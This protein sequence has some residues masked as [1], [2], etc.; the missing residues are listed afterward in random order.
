MMQNQNGGTTS[1]RIP[2]RGMSVELVLE[3]VSPNGNIEAV[4][5]QD[6]RAVFL[7]LR[8]DPE[9]DF[10]VRS[11]WVRN[12]GPAPATLDVDAM[13]NGSA[14]MLPRGNCAHPTGADRLEAT[15]LS[16]VW[17]EEGDAAALL[18]D[19]EPLAI[20]PAWSGTNGFEGYARDCTAESPLCWPLLADNDLHRRVRAAAEYWKAWDS[21]DDPWTV[22]QQPQITAYTDQVGQYEK[23]YAIDGGEWPPRA[24]LRI[25]VPGGVALTTVGI[26]LRPQPVVESVVERATEF[27]RIELGAGLAADAS[28]YF[29]P[30]ARYLS[31]QSNLPWT[32]Y[33]WLGP[34]H[35][36]PCDA[37]PD[38]DFTAVLLCREFQGAPSV[39]IPPFRGDPVN[40]LWAVPITRREREVAM[41]RGA[42]ELAR[43]LANAGIA[44]LTR[45]RSSVV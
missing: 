23:Y 3:E 18:E 41:E 13:R 36:I 42:A 9:I 7:Y 20:I 30:F 38:T 8:G 11:C 21:A 40:M 28:A 6:D 26:C 32:R 44:W 45:P 25:P 27:R 16:L 29:D 15:R 19:D 22:V 2:A 14:P 35:T 31:G 33:T 34:G 17:L 4:V 24:L 43:L 39:S 12:L 10:G 5:E 37:F 1:N